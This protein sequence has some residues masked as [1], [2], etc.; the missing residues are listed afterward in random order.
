MA[1]AEG[2]MPRVL[3]TGVPNL[4]RVLGGGLLWHNAYLFAGA[5]G[6]GKSVLSQ[7]IA[8][9][10]AREGER[11]LLLTG[12]DEPHR[13]LLEHLRTL[14]FADVSL[15]GPQIEI[16]SMAPFLEQPLADRVNVLRRTVLNVRPQ[17]VVLDGFRSFETFLPTQHEV[18]RFI[19]ELTSWFA[20]EGITLILTR[21]SGS[22]DLPDLPEYSLV[23]GVL[24][25]QSTSLSDSRCIRQ[26]IVQ[27]LR[28]AKHLPGPHPYT[29]DQDGV[30]VWPR[31]E[32]VFLAA[33]RPWSAARARF[34]ITS[35][36]T[37]LGG[38]LPQGAGS[39]LVGD[40]GSARTTLALS[41]LAAGQQEGETG[42]LVTLATPRGRLLGMAQQ[43]G[44]GLTESEAGGQVSL[45]FLAPFELTPGE[46]AA[47]IERAVSE[48]GARRLVLDAAEL[49]DEAF[50]SC[51]EARSFLAWLLLALPQQG[52]T[53]LISRSTL[54]PRGPWS[55]PARDGLAAL[56]ESVIL[57]RHVR[58]RGELGHAIAVLKMPDPEYDRTI[59][60]LILERKGPRVGGPLESEPGIPGPGAG[61]E[62][63]REPA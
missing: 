28:G 33:D 52:V 40:P 2:P 45:L 31:P 10:R 39:L 34:G 60:E 49:L 58:R 22:S 16:V 5:A 47:R 15:I 30:T 46:L 11:V 32:A 12:L 55:D 44:I 17:L 57:V 18:H 35:L 61:G 51:A 4:D 48:T 1:H 43:S 26:L 9:H 25:L 42:L 37:M 8:F 36:D 27:K 41:F 21:D 59:R 38:G 23:D 56:A 54:G 50:S 3:S 19:Y 6:T 14:R 53:T 13:N 24:L 20:V 62:P 63:A 7:Q 29:I